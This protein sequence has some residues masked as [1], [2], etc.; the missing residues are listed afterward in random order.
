M[1]GAKLTEIKNTQRDVEL[2]A[3]R[4]DVMLRE[5]SAMCRV[6]NQQLAI[7]IDECRHAIKGQ[8]NLPLNALA[9]IQAGERMKAEA[10]NG[11]SK[12]L[13]EEAAELRERQ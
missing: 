1:N 10:S 12:A 6:E 5:L 7:R 11:Q 4:L 2:L 13:P 3:K 9:M 8:L